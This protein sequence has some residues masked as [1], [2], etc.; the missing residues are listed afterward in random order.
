MVLE[1]HAKYSIDPPVEVFMKGDNVTNDSRYYYCFRIPQLLTLPSGTLMAFA[2]GRQD[3]CRPDVNVNR[4]IVSRASKDQGKTWGD[5]H[6]AGPALPNAGTNYP[7]A[8]M[9]D[10]TTVVLRYSL[11]N[12]SVFETESNDEGSTWS[13]PVNAS[14]PQG[15]K[16]GS[17]WPKM[18]GTDVVMPCGGGTA[19]SSDGG[20]SWKALFNLTPVNSNSPP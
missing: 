7:G 13:S 15:A 2:E 10:N 5:I 20:R 12:G 19:R 6:I 18:L 16:C 11:S 4:P 1:S 17:A 8:F 3:G 9:R 14:Q